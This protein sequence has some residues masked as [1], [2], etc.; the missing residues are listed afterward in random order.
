MFAQ[1]IAFMLNVIKMI[2]FKLI[3]S[4]LMSNVAGLTSYILNFEL[5][6]IT[7]I[8]I[9]LCIRLILPEPLGNNGRSLSAMGLVF[10][11]VNECKVKL[12]CWKQCQGVMSK[13]IYFT[14]TWVVTLVLFLHF[15]GSQSLHW[16]KLDIYAYYWL[17]ETLQDLK[18]VGLVENQ[19]I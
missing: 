5:T 11:N 3:Q 15:Q 7:Y 6:F 19:I 17:K 1:L 8:I 2:G 9:R 16:G 12:A 4:F 18:R 10:F 14:I 13:L